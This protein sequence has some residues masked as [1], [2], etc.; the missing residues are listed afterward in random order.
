MRQIRKNIG[1]NQVT[2]V[3]GP[4]KQIKTQK[5]LTALSCYQA[6]GGHMKLSSLLAQMLQLLTAAAACFEEGYGVPCSDAL[7]QSTL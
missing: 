7:Q 6:W 5:S 4:A 1:P 3:P 2:P